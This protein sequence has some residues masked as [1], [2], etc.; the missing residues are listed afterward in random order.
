[1]RCSAGNHTYRTARVRG[2]PLPVSSA[3]AGQDELEQGCQLEIV[4]PTGV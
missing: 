3:F 4:F 2:D 1:M